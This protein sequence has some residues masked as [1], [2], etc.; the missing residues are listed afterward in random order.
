MLMCSGGQWRDMLRCRAGHWWICLCA[1]VVNGGY[2]QVQ[3]CPKV[4]M[5]MCS[6][7]Q[8]R[9]MLRCRAGHWLDMPMCRGGQFWICSG[10]G[11]GA[12]VQWWSMVDMLT[13]RSDQLSI[14]SCAVML[15][16]EYA[17]V[18]WWS[19]EEYAHVQSLSLIHI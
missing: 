19:M 11:A 6:G 15:N 7:G 8:W 16:G 1:E 4:D 5:L 2:A 17:H 3:W 10:A 18:E 13:C 12:Q 9:D 14:C